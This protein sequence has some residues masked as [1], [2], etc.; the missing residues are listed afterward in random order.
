[1][2]GRLSLEAIS[3]RFLIRDGR[4]LFDDVTR[5]CWLS[6][7]EGGLAIGRTRSTMLLDNP[8]FLVAL[9]KTPIGC[10]PTLSGL[11]LRSKSRCLASGGLLPRQVQRDECAQCPDPNHDLGQVNGTAMSVSDSGNAPNPVTGRKLD[12]YEV[13][14]LNAVDVRGKI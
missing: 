10:G 14:S 12:S 7:S 1:M 6:L 2:M 8:E 4:R 3:S 11:T 5:R 9:H 13:D